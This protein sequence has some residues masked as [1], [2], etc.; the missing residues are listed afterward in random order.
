MVVEAM[1]GSDGVFHTS[2]GSRT[3]CLFEGD[4]RPVSVP[5]K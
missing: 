2:G 4:P 5:E 3:V 1:D